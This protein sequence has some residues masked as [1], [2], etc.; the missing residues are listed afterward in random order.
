MGVSVLGRKWKPM[1]NMFTFLPKVFMDKKGR[2]GAYNCPQ[3]VPENLV[4][5]DTFQWTK[6]VVLSTM[7]SLLS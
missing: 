6:A 3:L 5:N 2:Y 4:L 1:T 7:E